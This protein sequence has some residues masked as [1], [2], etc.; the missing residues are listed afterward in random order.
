LS[1]H[2]VLQATRNCFEQSK[3]HSNKETFPFNPFVTVLEDGTMRENDPAMC[4]DLMSLTESFLDSLE[5]CP[6]L[7]TFWMSDDDEN[8][9]DENQ[10]DSTCLT[11]LLTCSTPPVK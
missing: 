11:V 5:C 1:S 4:E 7:L 9:G 6:Q 2:R 8:Q 10:G 3:Y